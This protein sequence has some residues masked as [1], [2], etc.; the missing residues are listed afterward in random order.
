M[1]DWLFG[2]VLWAAGAFIVALGLLV[3]FHEYGHFW[4]ARKLGVRVLRYS[5]GFGRPIWRRVSPRTGIEY[6]IAAIPLGGYVKMLDEREGDVPE[7]QLGQAFNRQHVAKRI[8]IVAA[9]PLA[10]FLLAIVLYWAVFVI[11]TTGLKP[12]LAEVEQQTIAHAAGL[13]G[14]EQVRAVGNQSVESWEQLRPALIKAAL[15]DGPVTVQAVDGDG[16]GRAYVLDLTGVG[17][18]PERLFS[19]LGMDPARPT[20]PPVLASVEAGLAADRAGLQVGDRIVQPREPEEHYRRQDWA[21]CEQSAELN[22]E[23]PD[24]HG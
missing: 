18:D 17:A 20:V 16:D 4:V 19:R 15:T 3:A 2:N 1:A 22:S 13:R 23:H 6:V 5:I 12:V 9:G 14:G 10:N 11:G 8:A 7:S 21:E 24:Q